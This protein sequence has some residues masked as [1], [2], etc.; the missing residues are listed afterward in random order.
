MKHIV[1]HFFSFQISIELLNNT[2]NTN[3]HHSSLFATCVLWGLFH[4]RTFD[5]TSFDF[6]GNCNYKLGSTQSWQVNVNPINCTNWKKCSKKL[7]MLF[8]PVN[9]TA[10]GR[11]I[12][13]NGKLL[14]SDSGIIISGVSIE[15]HGNYTYLTYSE[16]VRVKWDEATVIGLTVDVTFKGSMSGL[17]GDYDGNSTSLFIFTILN[18]YANPTG[19]IYNFLL[20]DLRLND[21]RIASNPSIFANQWRTDT[22]VCTNKL[23]CEFNSVFRNLVR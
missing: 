20:D 13:V 15:R 4:Y 11:E 6:T 9:V 22:S 17:C 10:Q 12:I 18:K 5:G 16:G 2:I 8:G 19:F 23:P 14:A 3:Q 7:S 1:E 21:G